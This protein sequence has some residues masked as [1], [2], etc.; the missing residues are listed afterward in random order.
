MTTEHDPVMD[1]DAMCALVADWQRDGRT[2]ALCH[3]C[4]D[5]LHV[6]HIWHF[7][8]ARN[9]ADHLVVTL[10][11]DRYANKGPNRPVWDERQ[12]V[13]MV[14]AVSVVDAAALNHWP[15]AE[16]TLTRLRPDVY[17]KGQD[18]L[19][20]AGTEPGFRRE[21]EVVRRIG[22]RTYFT[23]TPKLSSTAMLEDADLLG[24]GPGVARM[25]SKGV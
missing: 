14:A 18:Y 21:L 25:P 19:G 23:T 3:G 13:T 2:V 4:F 6:G 17:V 11:P 24:H 9:C 7:A 5:P 1:L 12:R 16:E 10:T 22:A 15:T 8:A 20:E